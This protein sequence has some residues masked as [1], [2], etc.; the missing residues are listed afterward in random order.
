MAAI[1]S[2]LLQK[3][4]ALSNVLSVDREALNLVL[5]LHEPGGAKVSG[6][7]TLS[8][9]HVTV[10][11]SEPVFHILG[12]ALFTVNAGEAHRT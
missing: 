11:N 6:V 4:P 7:I 9:I 3:C 5:S 10:S 1:T 8:E 2:G 12:M